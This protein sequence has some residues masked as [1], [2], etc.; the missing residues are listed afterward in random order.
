L[1]VFLEYRV[2]S[3]DVITLFLPLLV[4]PAMEMY[5]QFYL[6]EGITWSFLRISPLRVKTQ[7]LVFYDKI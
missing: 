6:V 5:R 7:N 3:A 2:L 1:A 4:A